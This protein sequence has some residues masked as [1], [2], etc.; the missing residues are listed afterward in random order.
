MPEYIAGYFLSDEY[1]EFIMKLACG[2]NINNLKTEHI[3][4]LMI[5]LPSIDLQERFAVFVH[6]SD[7]LKL[8]LEQ[9]IAELDA[10][11]KK[12]ILDNFS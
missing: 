2:S 5:P 9:S 8:E 11:Y 7:K 12:I 3:D 1:R 4:S 10:I 6:Q